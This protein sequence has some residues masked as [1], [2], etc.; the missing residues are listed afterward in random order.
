[1]TFY[2][3]SAQL[4]NLIGPVVIHNLIPFDYSLILKQNENIALT[5][6]IRDTGITDYTEL[7]I[8]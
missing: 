1:M 2:L 8:K 5:S 6:N 3:K 4:N 7:L